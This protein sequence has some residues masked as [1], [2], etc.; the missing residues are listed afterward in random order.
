MFRSIW[1]TAW[2][3]RGRELHDL[4]PG[5]V[6]VVSVEAV[7]PVSA[8]LRA[9]E[10]LQAAGTKLGGGGVNVFYAEREMILH[11]EFFVVGVRRNV[12][13]VFDPVGA[14]G[15]LK[16]VPVGAV[17]FEPSVPVKAKAEQIHVEA[18]LS[19]HVFDY[20]AGVDQVSADG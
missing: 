9:I 11:S 18:I 2:L 12:E 13:H 10:C 4:N 16:F 20:E 19:G 14:V 5:T 6:R 15:N 17:V 8:D 7:F 3:L 1:M